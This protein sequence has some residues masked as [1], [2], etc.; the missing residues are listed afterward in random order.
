MNVSLKDLVSKEAKTNKQQK[1][2]Q[3]QQNSQNSQQRLI[4]FPKAQFIT[5]LQGTLIPPRENPLSGFQQGPHKL[6]KHFFLIYVFTY[7]SIYF[8]LALCGRASCG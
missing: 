1:Q 6:D 4:G 7:L 5:P 2:E 3:Q 8:N